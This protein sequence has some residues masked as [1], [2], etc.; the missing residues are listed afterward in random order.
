MSLKFGTDGLR[1]PADELTDELVVARGRAAARVLGAERFVIGRDTRASGPRLAGALAAG[2]AAE[3]GRPERLGVVPTPTV[4]WVAAAEGCP[5]AVVSASHN[6]WADNGIKLFAA[7][8]HKLADA[9]EAQLE[10]ELAAVVDQ[11]RAEGGAA[12]TGPPAGSEEAA[13]H[14]AGWGASVLGSLA[15]RDLAGLSVVVDCANGAA[16]T[17]GPDLLRR[18][19]A[20][21]GVLHAEPDGRNINDGCGSTHPEALQAAVVAAGADA[22]LA[23]DGDADRVLAVDEA[24]ALVDGDQLI[25]MLAIDRHERGVL[26][27][28][29]VV[30]TVLSNLG[31]RLSMAERGIAVVDTPVGDRH[32]LEALEH[33]DLVLGGEQSGHIILRDLAT[34]GDGV[35]AGIQVLDVLRRSGRPLSALVAEAMQRLPQVLRNVPVA[36]RRSDVAEVLAEA[37]A[38]EEARLGHTGRV[39]IRPSGTEPL[40]RVMVEAP[41]Q[42]VAEA[43]A[44][45]LEAAVLEV[46]GR[47]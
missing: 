29:A 3:G 45:R 18:L 24:G 34:T 9:V 42:A 43:V 38:A 5:G 31:F 8:G 7:G 2:I 41:D 33:R 12:P 35:L 40:I 30:V 16:S 26:V 39:L 47:P 14:V 23:F 37:V 27:G 21:V 11:A 13:A 10:A 6:P 1:G 17:V 25:A 20:T 32:V 46:C 44:T 15:G 36:E 4:A 19:G 22:G 28:D